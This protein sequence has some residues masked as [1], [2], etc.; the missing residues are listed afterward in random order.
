MIATMNAASSWVRDGFSGVTADHLPFPQV[1][2]SMT[3]KTSA[4]CVPEWTVVA[5]ET[6]RSTIREFEPQKPS[7]TEKADQTYHSQELLL[8]LHK[9]MVSFLTSGRPIGTNDVAYLFEA[10]LLKLRTAA[11]YLRELHGFSLLIH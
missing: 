6:S 3:L 11:L 5:G 9:F 7:A 8:S 10:N 4:K 2:Y 1:E